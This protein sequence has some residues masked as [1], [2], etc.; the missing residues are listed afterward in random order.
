MLEELS[1]PLGSHLHPFLWGECF[2]LGCHVEGLLLGRLG[3]PV[4]WAHLLTS[5]TSVDAPAQLLCHP[6]GQWSAMLYGKVR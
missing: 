3:Q 4:V 1:V 6:L 5:V 2:H